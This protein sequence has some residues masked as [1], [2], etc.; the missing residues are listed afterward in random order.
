MNEIEFEISSKCNLKCPLCVRTHT[1]THPE[2]LNNNLPFNSFTEILTNMP[3]TKIKFCGVSGDPFAN[4]KL[5]KY[6]DFAISKNI[7]VNITTNGTLGNISLWK[8]LALLGEEKKI[9]ITLSIDG[10]KDTNHLYRINAKWSR[11]IKRLETI[12]NINHG[13]E[14][15][16]ITFDHNKHQINEIKNFAKM[17]GCS[18][19]VLPLLKKNSMPDISKLSANNGEGTNYILK[20][21]IPNVTEFDCVHEKENTLFVD[22]KGNTW[23]CF[24]HYDH[25]LR[26]G[27]DFETPDFNKLLDHDNQDRC[28]HSCGKRPDNMRYGCKFI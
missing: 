18:F 19:F 5:E 3:T 10:L 15:K 24:F 1:L 2:F 4:N 11:I 13:F 6:I 20:T 9:K 12:K 26:F 21:A 16:V 17:Y 8:K 25:Y 22:V 7:F 14:W 28:K 27:Y 23:P